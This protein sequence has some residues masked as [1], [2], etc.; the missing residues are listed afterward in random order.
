MLDQ[1]EEGDQDY[2]DED[3]NDEKWFSDSSTSEN[4]DGEKQEREPRLI[5]YAAFT[6]YDVVKEV[7]KT[8]FNFHL[9]KDETKDW[10]IAWFDGA[11]SLKLL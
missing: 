10:D 2:G 5:M 4:E 11:I 3:N 8:V 6:Q 1:E 9:T 7:G